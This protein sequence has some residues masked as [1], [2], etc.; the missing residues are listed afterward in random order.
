MSR[1]TDKLILDGTT[2]AELLNEAGWPCERINEDTWLSRLRGQ[3]ATFPFFVRVDPE[4]H[5]SFAIVPYVR[6][7][8]SGEVAER[9]Y[10]RLLT[11]NHALLMAKFSIDDDL[12][13][14]LSVEYPTSQI[15][16]SEFRD[17]VEALGFYA[18][19]HHAELS[20]LVDV[21]SAPG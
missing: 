17:A 16:R 4:G 12:D 18:D 11:L 1:L 3:D 8:E 5:V 6:S 14:V 2:I 13:V 7:P 15:D 10:A 21:V 20:A 19:K 9:L